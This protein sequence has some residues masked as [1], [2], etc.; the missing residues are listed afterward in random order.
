MS[1]I[2]YL[3]LGHFEREGGMVRFSKDPGSRVYGPVVRK[4][5]DAEAIGLLL[6]EVTGGEGSRNDIPE[7]WPIYL[8]DGYLV[9]DK[10]SRDPEVIRF[11][12]VLVRQTGCDIYD[13]AA[14]CDI[15]LNA[16]LVE[17]RDYARP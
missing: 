16:W 9:C 6:R 1:L 10:Y 14:H 2:H 12:K 3:F 4:P 5:L 15:A 8:K 7:G 17:L 11:V 13:V